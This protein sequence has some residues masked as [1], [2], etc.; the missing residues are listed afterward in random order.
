[1]AAGIAG[2][3]Y[4]L[5]VCRPFGGTAVGFLVGACI[6]LVVGVLGWGYVFVTVLRVQFLPLTPQY[7]PLVV[8]LV[9]GPCPAHA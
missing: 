7:G 6:P 9:R 4:S 2:I 5:E 8:E 1:M 3:A